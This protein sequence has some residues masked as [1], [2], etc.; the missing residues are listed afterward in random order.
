MSGAAQANDTRVEVPEPT[1]HTDRKY[2]VRA[3]T[4]LCAST[5]LGFAHD[6]RPSVIL[7]LRSGLV[8]VRTK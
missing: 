3:C 1:S 5:G 4:T 6:T 8:I 2:R 7:S